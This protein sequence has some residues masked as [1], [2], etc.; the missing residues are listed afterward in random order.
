M[1]YAFARSA[2]H[3]IKLNGR[4][5]PWVDIFPSSDPT[6]HLKPIPPGWL[7]RGSNTLQIV[8]N[9]PAILVHYAVV[10]WL[11]RDYPPPPPPVH[12]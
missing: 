3:I 7:V 2:G 12:P 6:T 11:E 9:G 10:H 1:T 5:L 8:L 4:D